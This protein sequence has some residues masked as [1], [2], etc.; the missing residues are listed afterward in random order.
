MAAIKKS[1]RLVD[2]TQATLHNL[3]LTGEVNWSGSIND[4]AAQ[5]E[6]FVNDNTPELT[7]KEW[8]VF[9]CAYNGYMPSQDQEREARMLSWHISE[10]YQYDEQIREF[11]GSEAAAVA[12]IDRVKSW[13]LSQQLAVIYKAK[14]FWRKG[15]ED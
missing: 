14:S 7:A 4:M 3:T 2:K 11:I 13:S 5:F 10:G 12:L 6:L 1:V 8:N 15:K 9:Y